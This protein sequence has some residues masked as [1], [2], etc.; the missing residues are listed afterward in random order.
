MVGGKVKDETKIILSPDE[1]G[2]IIR[3]L[4]SG[5][6]A[7]DRSVQVPSLPEAISA[8]PVYRLIATEEGI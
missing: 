2:D 6:Q 5:H 7:F 1:R 8:V 3:K 4:F